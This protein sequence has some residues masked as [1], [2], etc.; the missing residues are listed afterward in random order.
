MTQLPQRLPRPPG[1]SPFRLRGRGL[2]KGGWFLSSAS[3]LEGRSLTAGG[4]VL[5]QAGVT[6]GQAHGPLP[7][8]SQ[9]WGPAAGG[10]GCP[11]GAREV[12]VC[13]SAGAVFTDA[14]LWTCGPGSA[15]LLQGRPGGRTS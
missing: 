4:G 8:L 7:H 10:A 12:W 15:T 6:L 14:A 2:Q 1:L 11:T 13:L 9:G 5:D 3:I